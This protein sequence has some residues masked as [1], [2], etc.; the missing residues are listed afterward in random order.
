[1]NFSIDRDSS[2]CEKQLRL[3]GE[4][5]LEGLYESNITVNFSNIS[6]RLFKKWKEAETVL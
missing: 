3:L 2:R 4:L 5:M 6:P 1:V